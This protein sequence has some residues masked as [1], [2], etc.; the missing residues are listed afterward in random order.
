MTEATRK[1]A[2]KP[3][4]KPTAKKSSAPSAAAPA[5]AA[6]PVKRRSRPVSVKPAPTTPAAKKSV[7]GKPPRGVDVPVEQLPPESK[8][9]KANKARLV[10]DSFTMP[11]SEYAAIAALKKRCLGS[12]VAAKKS[13][14]LR[15]A[16]S[17]FAK[18]DDADVAAA[19]QG[20]DAI[21]TGR[22]AK[23]AK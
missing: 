13:E 3:A 11:E 21:K 16:I 9:A 5:D 1:A 14:I 23:A 20:L 17:C 7:A 15:A 6:V 4:A 12:G 18:L 22:P 2:T 8:P 19:I 10:R